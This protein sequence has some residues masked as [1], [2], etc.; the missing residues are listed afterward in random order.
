M[1]DLDLGKD[2]KNVKLAFK[3]NFLCFELN[4]NLS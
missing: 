2:S 4:K 1:K 3:A